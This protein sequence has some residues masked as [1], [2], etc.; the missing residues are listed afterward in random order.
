MRHDQALISFMKNCGV[1][2]RLTVMENT[3]AR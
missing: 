1:I 2:P 3:N